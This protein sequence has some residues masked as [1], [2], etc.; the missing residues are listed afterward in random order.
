M[1]LIRAVGVSGLLL[2]GAATQLLLYTTWR[3]SGNT[4]HGQTCASIAEEGMGTCLSWCGTTGPPIEG[5]LNMYMDCTGSGLTKP[6]SLYSALTRSDLEKSRN[7][8]SRSC[9]ACPILLIL[10]PF[11]FRSVP[12]S[13]KAPSSKKHEMLLALSRKYCEVSFSCMH[14]LVAH[15]HKPKRGYKICCAS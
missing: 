5:C 9:R 2:V 4:V 8:G 7:T 3:K 11:G 13:S 1:N 10:R 15:A 6:S 14:S 12:V